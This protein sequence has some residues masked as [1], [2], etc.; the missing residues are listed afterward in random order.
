FY[1]PDD[2]RSFFAQRK[3]ELAKESAA[4]KDRFEAWSKANPDLRKEWDAAFS[5]AVPED[6][7]SHLPEVDPSAAVATR[8]AGGKAEQALAKAVPYL[9]GGSADLN[10]STKTFID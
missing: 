1:V 6:L 9:V 3:E 7:A 5:G 10:P 2:V 8:A 4:W